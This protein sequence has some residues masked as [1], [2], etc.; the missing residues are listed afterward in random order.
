VQQSLALIDA[1]H[2]SAEMAW[3]A[4]CLG[5]VLYLR[6]DWGAARSAYERAIQN[7]R[8]VGV[9]RYRSYVLLHRAELSACEGNWTP[10]RQDIDEGLAVA[11]TCGAVP[12]LREGQRLLAER[13]L[14]EGRPQAAIDRLLPLLEQATGDWPR[15]FPPPVLAEAYLNLD[16]VA[17]AEDLVLQRVARFRAHSHRRALALWLRVQGMVLCRQQ[18]CQ[19]AGSVF[20]EAGSLAHAMPYPYAEGRI[21]YEDGLLHRESGAPEQ[22]RERLAQ[23]LSIFQQLSAKQ[24]AVLTA[25]ALVGLR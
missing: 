14:R 4:G 12:A 21:L 5:E 19:E 9:D 3:I 8:E 11:G 22:A 6:G 23:A 2:E 15:A 17:K 18:R 20:A 10:A 24:D 25:H 7:A 13:D 1:A 16:E